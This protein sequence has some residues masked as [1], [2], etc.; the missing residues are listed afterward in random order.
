MLDNLLNWAR[1]QLQHGQRISFVKTNINLIG[2]DIIKQYSSIA[3]N[4]R[5]HLAYEGLNQDAFSLTD[6][7]INRIV[8][9]NLINNSIKFTPKGGTV[10]LSI[11]LSDD[12]DYTIIRVSD[13]GLGMSLETIEKIRNKTYY[14]SQGTNQETGTGLGLTLSISLLDNLN[15]KLEIES[16]PGQGSTFYYLLPVLK[17]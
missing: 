15:S 14:T 10:K 1:L 13:N 12:G 9:R 6:P 8:L 11:L 16:V 17:S 2:A 4:K 3:A 5:I 7:E